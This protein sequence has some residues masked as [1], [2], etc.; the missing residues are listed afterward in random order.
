MNP[1]ADYSIEELERLEKEYTAKCKLLYEVI[2]RLDN[3]KNTVHVFGLQV[4]STLLNFIATSM[5]F[6][7]SLVIE[8]GK[9]I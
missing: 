5:P 4:G 3:R 9:Q 7:M 2:A 6:P 1:V 8:A